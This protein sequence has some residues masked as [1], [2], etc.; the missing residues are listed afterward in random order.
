[1]VHSSQRADYH[2]F[3]VG[4]RSAVHGLRL[5]FPLTLSTKEYR[6]LTIDHKTTQLWTIDLQPWTLPPACPTKEY[7]L[8]IDYGPLTIDLQLLTSS[9]G[10]LTVNQ[11][12]KVLSAVLFV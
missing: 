10:P 9:Y 3:V 11:I 4:R 2:S 1:M 8:T 12:F 6:L 7:R 5:S